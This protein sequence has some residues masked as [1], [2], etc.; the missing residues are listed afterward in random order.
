MDCAVCAVAK[1]RMRIYFF[2]VYGR[3]PVVKQECPHIPVRFY[4]IEMDTVHLSMVNVY[5]LPIW[6]TLEMLKAN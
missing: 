1:S 6:E 3:V 5:K 2:T 4:G